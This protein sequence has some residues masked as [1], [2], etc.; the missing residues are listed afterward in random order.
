MDNRS[1]RDFIESLHA[2]SRLTNAPRPS[3]SSMMGLSGFLRSARDS[4]REES[5]R[6]RGYMESDYD[7][8]ALVSLRPEMLRMCGFDPEQDER[9]YNA[10]SRMRRRYRR[11]SSSDS[12]DSPAGQG[13]SGPPPMPKFRLRP[14]RSY[15]DIMRLFDRSERLRKEKG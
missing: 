2:S 3:S 11:T 12:D 4:H 5:L 10:R 8:E 6:R 15:L 1:L 7:E 9:E 14:E 13:P